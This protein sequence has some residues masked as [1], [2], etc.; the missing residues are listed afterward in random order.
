MLLVSDISSM[1]LIKVYIGW[2]YINFISS[3]IVIESKEFGKN[4]VLQCLLKY[5]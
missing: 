2:K 3:Y 1:G 5:D 4:F